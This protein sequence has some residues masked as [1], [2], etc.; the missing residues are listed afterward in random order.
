MFETELKLLS[1]GVLLSAVATSLHSSKIFLKSVTQQKPGEHNQCVCS[2]SMDIFIT[3]VN[4]CGNDGRKILLLIDMG[5]K[6]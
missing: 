4:V 2:G 3:R 1:K 6:R 5:W